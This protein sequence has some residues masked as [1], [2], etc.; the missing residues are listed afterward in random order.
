MDRAKEDLRNPCA[1]HGLWAPLKPDG[2]RW[3]AALLFLT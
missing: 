2:V 1:L 3:L